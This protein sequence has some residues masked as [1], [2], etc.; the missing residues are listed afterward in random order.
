MQRLHAVGRVVIRWY[1][2]EGIHHPVAV[3]IGTE[4]AFVE[5]GGIGMNGVDV[6]GIHLP[7]AIYIT[8]E[9]AED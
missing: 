9:E 8:G 7:V 5:E 2:I 4:V 1:Q 3:H 6:G